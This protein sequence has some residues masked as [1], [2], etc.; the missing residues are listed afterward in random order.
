MLHGKHLEEG[1]PIRVHQQD[2]IRHVRESLSPRY[3]QMLVSASLQELPGHSN[4]MVQSKLVQPC[5][6]F[7]TEV[8]T[9]N[10]VQG[11]LQ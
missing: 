5:P 9:K 2:S 3:E 10:Q 7:I 1:E 8:E 11:H 6:K 4:V